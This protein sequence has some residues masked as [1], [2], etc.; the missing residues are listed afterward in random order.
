MKKNNKQK[1][2]DE[3]V[4]MDINYQCGEECE[5]CQD[6]DGKE[7]DDC[8]EDLSESEIGS[9]VDSDFKLLP[10]FMNT[11]NIAE[12]IKYD[13]DEFQDGVN[14]FSKLCGQITALMNA[15][16]SE[17]SILQ[18]ISNMDILENNLKIT[19]SN[20]HA[21]IEMSKN[22]KVLIQNEEL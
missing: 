15:G 6:Y 2:N 11:E 16:L 7:Y 13:E 3:Y 10:I 21:S 18:L 1:L 17:S 12:K 14:S 20:N 8:Q 19:E 4:Y 9:V 22:Q 5:N